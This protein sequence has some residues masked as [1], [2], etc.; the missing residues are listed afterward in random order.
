VIRLHGRE[1]SGSYN[2]G[3]FTIN[4]CRDRGFFPDGALEINAENFTT[5]KQ[6]VQEIGDNF[7][8]ISFM[9]VIKKLSNMK[10]VI[11]INRCSKLIKNDYESFCN[12]LIELTEKT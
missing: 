11:M 12:F 10:I 6:L 9:D 8:L 5:N 1:T 4:Y 3:L 7:E 2:L